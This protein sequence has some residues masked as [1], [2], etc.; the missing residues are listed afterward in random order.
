MGDAP[1]LPNHS[2]DDTLSGMRLTVTLAHNDGAELK[3]E[4]LPK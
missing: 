4:K 1:L 2:L 3:V